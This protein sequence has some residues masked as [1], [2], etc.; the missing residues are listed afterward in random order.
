MARTTVSQLGTLFSVPLLSLATPYP[1]LLTD[2]P[3]PFYC[4]ETK[5]VIRYCAL[6]I[7]ACDLCSEIVRDGQVSS[8]CEGPSYTTASPRQIFPFSKLGLLGK[9]KKEPQGQR[10]SKGR[11]E[12]DVAIL[13]AG[14]RKKQGQEMINWEG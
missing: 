3:A 13:Q 10:A 7:P 8:G 1:L 9:S 2:L 6:G 14:V 11:G 4:R 5:P 12:T